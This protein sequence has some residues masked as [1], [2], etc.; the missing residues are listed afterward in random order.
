MNSAAVVR[1]NAQSEEPKPVLVWYVTC[2]RKHY[3]HSSVHLSH[4]FIGFVYGKRFDSNIFTYIENMDIY[5]FT[6]PKKKL[7]FGKENYTLIRC[8]IVTCAFYAL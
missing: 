2:E 7:H 4:W 3:T 1:F 8:T 6:Q 5:F